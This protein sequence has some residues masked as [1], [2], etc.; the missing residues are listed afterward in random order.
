MST[1]AALNHRRAYGN[2][3]SGINEGM[4][5]MKTRIIIAAIFAAALCRA[6]QVATIS[7]DVQGTAD[8]ATTV[9]GSQSNTIASITNYL[10]LAGGNM[11]GALGMGAQAITNI[12]PIQ[13][14]GCVA[15]GSYSPVAMGSETVAS[16]SEGAISLGFS[17]V[18]SGGSGAVA[19]GVSSVASGNS[20]AT[21]MGASTTASGNSGATAMGNFT[22]ASGNDG[23]FAIGTYSISSNTSSFV[24]S[25]T[26][27]SYGSR[28]AGTFCINPI[29]GVNGFWIGAQ[30][31]SNSIAA[32]VTTHA[33][34]AATASVLGHVK[35][36]INL[37]NST[38]LF[39]GIYLG[40]NAVA[41][42]KNGTNYWIHLP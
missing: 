30:T 27:D 19:M 42:R 4:D 39:D 10:P 28:G 23:A 15:S 29:G 6:E 11:T 12:G 25:G 32:Q 2:F 22:T 40:T 3:T 13:G 17:T 33:G 21:A 5:G 26:G 18:A 36:S 35:G 38:A 14:A 20:G 34:T 31:V 37:T 24:W 16:G 8:R 1:F 9:V 41:F 7:L